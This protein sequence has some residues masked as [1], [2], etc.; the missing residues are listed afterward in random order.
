MNSGAT[1]SLYIAQRTNL[2]EAECPV[3]QDTLPRSRY[4]HKRERDVFLEPEKRLMFAILEDAIRCFQDNHLAQ[5][6]GSKRLFDEVQRWIFKRGDDC[7]FGFENICSVLGLDPGYI[8]R[9]LV[10]WRQEESRPHHASL[11]K[12]STMKVAAEQKPGCI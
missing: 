8:R 7:V 5:R 3:Q 4:F 10:R 11:W 6:G 1:N 9:G 12:G 2:A